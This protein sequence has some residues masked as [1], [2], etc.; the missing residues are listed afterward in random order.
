MNIGIFMWD[1]LHNDLN[2]KDIKIDWQKVQNNTE[3]SHGNSK[4]SCDS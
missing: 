4:P 3:F 2:F 1:K